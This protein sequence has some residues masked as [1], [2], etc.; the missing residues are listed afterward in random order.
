MIS[1]GLA[2][3]LRDNGLRWTPVAGDRFIVAD[4]DMDEHVL[5][6]AEMVIEAEDVPTGRLIRFNGTTEWALDSIREED[7][8][9]L[10]RE[11]QLRDG[12]G[13]AF[14]SLARVD[15]GYRVRTMVNGVDRAVEDLD[16]EEA[17]AL[18][19]LDLLV[20]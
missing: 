14:R 4:R 18:A 13:D 9:W 16:A 2:K 8:V 5:V 7:A 17:Y 3:Q 12:L 11:T 20:A 19:L 1:I 6:I 15:G 10:P